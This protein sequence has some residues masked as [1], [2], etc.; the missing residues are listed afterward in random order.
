VLKR[1]AQLMVDTIRGNDLAGRYGGEE[2]IVLLPKRHT[3][4]PM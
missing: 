4:L 1:F 3:Q 2:F